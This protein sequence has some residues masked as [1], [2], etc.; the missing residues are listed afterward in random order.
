MKVLIACT[1]EEAENENFD[2]RKPLH[3]LEYRADQKPRNR[4]QRH[5]LGTV[6]ELPY[7]TG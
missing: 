7:C 1:D 5:R 2:R 4:S 3:T 6:L